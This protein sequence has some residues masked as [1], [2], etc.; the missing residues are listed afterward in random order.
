[1]QS[2]QYKCR[3]MGLEPTWLQSPESSLLMVITDQKDKEFQKWSP[4]TS[5]F[6]Q[7]TDI[8]MYVHTSTVYWIANI[9]GTHIVFSSAV[10]SSWHCIWGQD[11]SYLAIWKALLPHH[12][13]LLHP[14]LPSYDIW[15]S[16]HIESRFCMVLVLPNP[17]EEKCP[18]LPPS[19]PFLIF[20]SFAPLNIP[21]AS[22]SP[23][24][25]NE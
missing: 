17:Q 1:M 3:E 20:M 12:L 23:P 10:K 2:P 13:F 11:L 25:W 6:I 22:L 9:E 21:P 16:T 18:L 7:G 5:W 14:A 15:S 19:L 4:S 8:K 24:G